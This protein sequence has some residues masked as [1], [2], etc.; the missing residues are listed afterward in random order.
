MID[1]IEQD[2]IAVFSLNRPDR[3]NALSSDDVATMRDS[4]A[5][6][7]EATGLIVIKGAGGRAFC[8]GIDALE[9][10]GMDAGE[11]Q[12][13]VGDFLDLCL[14]VWN[15]P[16]LTIAVIDGYAVGGGAHLALSV[17]L[18]F[19]TAASWFQFPA[20]RY[21]LGISAVWLGWLVGQGESLLLMS[22]V[23]RIGCD[24]AMELGLVH[25]TIDDTSGDPVEL[26]GLSS[27]V[28]HIRDVKAFVS[29]SIPPGLESALLE[30]RAW[31]IDAAG[32]AE[33]V[34]MLGRER[35]AR[36]KR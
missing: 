15:H 20:G 2:G 6:L 32:T 25:R 14:E 23:E 5:T 36:R 9:I 29:R 13:T 12:R 10:V 33:F 22:S 19:A 31:A 17:D 11:R 3:G 4:L 21:G 28:S 30:E 24:R 7:E 34:E 18:R 8:G 26:L 35:S 1:V 16:A 27:D